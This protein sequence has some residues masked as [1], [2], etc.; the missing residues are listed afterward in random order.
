MTTATPPRWTEYLPVADLQPALRNAKDHDQAALGSSVEA[1]GMVE[2]VVMDERTGRLLAGHGRVEYL[3]RLQAEGADPPDGVLVADDGRWTWLVVR[4]IASRDDAHAEAMGIALNR[5]G[6]RGG[7]QVDVLNEALD[8]LWGTDLAAAVGWTADELD[9]LIASTGGLHTDAQPTDAAHAEHG[10]RGDPQTPR[11]VQGLHEVG[12]MFAAEQ[13]RDYLDL[14]A[15]LRR[16][17]SLDAAP[18]VVLRALRE[19]A[20]RL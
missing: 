3:L 6:E 9:D 5:V 8:A 20:D 14:L 11:Q 16:A 12:L 17:W 2:P 13:H 19:A 18:A 4:G 10:G 7:W 1:F 15:R